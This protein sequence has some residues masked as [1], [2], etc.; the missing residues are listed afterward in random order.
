[1]ACISESDCISVRCESRFAGEI[2]SKSSR[3]HNQ[4]QIQFFDPR[5]NCIW[6]FFR[7]LRFCKLSRSVEPS[8]RESF[9]AII[10][11]RRFVDSSIRRGSRGCTNHQTVVAWDC[12]TVG[13]SRPVGCTPHWTV[14]PPGRLAGC[15]AI[16]AARRF[17][18]VWR[19]AVRLVAWHGSGR[20][21]RPVRGAT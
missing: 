10:A 5:K 6:L 4:M 14:G 20:V 21:A 15:H 9:C 18:V 17:G 3:F 16:R 7:F 1:M 12:T 11:S 8:N 19:V 2:S 13:P